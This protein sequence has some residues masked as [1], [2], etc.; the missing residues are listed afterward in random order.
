M[1]TVAD[2]MRMKEQKDLKGLL[3]ALRDQ[4][5][6]VRAEAASS[7]GQLGNRNAVVALVTTLRADSDPY[8][9][10]LAAKALG[11]LGDPR[12]K[13][14][15]MNCL[16]ND[17]LEVSAVA[18]DALGQLEASIAA[19]KSVVQEK[20]A[21]RIPTKVDE[22]P[23]G[24]KEEQSIP[25]HKKAIGLIIGLEFDPDRQDFEELLANGAIKARG[26]Q[27]VTAKL[28]VKEAM[29]R[30][31]LRNYYKAACVKENWDEGL[32]YA[33]SLKFA[34][35]VVSGKS[36]VI[37]EPPG[38]D[39]PEV[40]PGGIIAGIGFTP[41]QADLELL[42]REVKL[43]PGY[44]YVIQSYSVS[45]ASSETLVAAAY[46][47]VARRQGW[48]PLSGSLSIQRRT[49]GG[50]DFL[51]VLPSLQ[52]EAVNAG[53]KATTMESART[54]ARTPAKVGEQSEGATGGGAHTDQVNAVAVTPDGR[55]AVS[56]SKDKSI[57]VWDISSGELVATHTSQREVLSV[58]VTA[59]GGRILFGTS[60]EYVSRGLQVAEINSKARLLDLHS[61][62]EITSFRHDGGVHAVAITPDGRR[63]VSGSGNGEVKVWNLGSGEE[64][65]TFG[66]G[67][68][69]KPGAYA[70]AIAPDGRLV[71]SVSGFG[72][73][74]LWDLDS[75]REEITLSGHNHVAKAVAITPDGRWIVSGSRDKTVK[76]WNLDSGQ[77][78]FTF[79][80]HAEAVNAVAVTPDGQVVVSASSD[81]TLKVWD[82]TRRREVHTLEGHTEEVRAVAVT[83]D[84]KY[85]LSASADQSLKIWSLD[86]GEHVRTLT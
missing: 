57:K 66:Q 83:P 75:G 26:F 21:D 70:V 16:A 18:C 23:Q 34:D 56:G 45:D 35:I 85:V 69:G 29:D 86:H 9:R 30:E 17:S 81:K 62:E 19:G 41:A 80:G 10:S 11:L 15:L 55:Y 2:V 14:A 49:I 64:E 32:A 48:P 59:D 1:L 3:R 22:L 54:R 58:T 46:V 20:P 53:K 77:E 63:I 33:N 5:I 13:E 27:Y 7:L 82:L 50:K 40:K 25:A 73:L 71:V 42:A 60:G 12:A 4:D 44:E 51:L 39:E 74:K 47:S 6:A 43:Q 36:V 52:G 76:V 67:S 8:V 79:E 84:G 31:K 28:S 72:D 38:F 61:G 37:V 65:L 68:L 24:T 78:E